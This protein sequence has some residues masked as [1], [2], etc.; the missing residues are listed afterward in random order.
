MSD[1]ELTPVQ[2]TWSLTWPPVVDAIRALSGR[3]GATVYIV[4]GAVRDAYMNRPVHD[5]DLVTAGDALRVARTIAN[6]LDGAYYALDEERGVGRAIVSFEGVRYEIDVARLRGASL[7]ED[8]AARDFTANAMAVQLD[9]DPSAIFDPLN[10]LADIKIKRLRRCT[11]DAIASDPIR[12]LRAVRQSATL[13]LMIEPATRADVRN[14]G[15]LL[16]NVSAERVRDEFFKMLDIPNPHAALRALDTLGLLERIIPEVRAMH[17]VTQGPPHVYDVWEHT[18][19][20]VEALDTVLQVISPKRTDE[21][22]ADSNFGMIVYVLDR[23]RKRLQEHLAVDWSGGRSSRSL[24]I[25]GALLHDCGKPATRTVDAEGRIHFYQHEVI[26]ADMARARAIAL[27]LSNDET[28]QL[29]TVVRQHMRPMHLSSAESVSRRAIYRFWNAS[30]AAGL[31]VCILTQADYIGVY[32]ITLTLQEWI[33]YLE[34]VNT[35]LDGYFNQYTTLVAP[36]PFLDGV[37]LMETLG[38][39]PGPLVGKLLRQIS[40]AQATGEVTTREEAI[41]LA[42]KAQTQPASAP[43]ADNE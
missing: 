19:K 8:L 33:A 9:G 38:L 23:Y 42:Q 13:K 25:L 34:I 2:L 16:Q 27:R 12:A 24:A 17:G 39:T 35:L 22:A 14:A 41:A 18:L 5:L 26:G 32:G 30:G 21:T 1:A 3:F 6:K 43:P 11:P 28:E 37:Q 20:V 15:S 10:G 36:P 40:E 31:D 4:G 7:T 29:T